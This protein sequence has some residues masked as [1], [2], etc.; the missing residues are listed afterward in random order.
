MT[1]SEHRR[2][3]PF[4]P[5]A[6][7][8]A[9]GSVQNETDHRL[10]TRAVC[11]LV[12]VK[13]EIFAERCTGVGSTGAPAAAVAERA[14]KW[15]INFY[16]PFLGPSHTTKLHRLAVHLL[17]EFRLRGN[18]F[19]G[20][21]GYNATLHKAVKAAYKAPNK[22]RD[23]FVEQLLVN[24]Q[25]AAL[26]LEE[27]ERPIAA[28]SDATSVHAERRSRPLRFSHRCTAAQLARKRKLPGLCT[29][30]EVEDSAS[31]FYCDSIYYG[32]PSAPR[33]G[34]V[35]NTIR[36]AAS[37]HGAPWYDWLQ[38]RGPGGTKCYGQAAL[39]VQSRSGRRK[40]L[41][42]RRA[43]EA[44]PREGCVL[45]DYGCQRLRWAVPSSGNA[46]RLDVVEVNDIV[47]WVAV[48]HDW[49]D[50][51]ERH[52]LLVMPNAVPST[53]AELRAARFFVNAFAVSDAGEETD[54]E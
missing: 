22:R 17:E 6:V 31:L 41:V 38:Y 28:G 36:A 33:R 19:D 32:N 35:A 24:Q 13:N 50:L 8:A 45:S 5:F 51:C 18:L 14:Q 29:V 27:V 23:Q 21:T 43:E 40:R 48:E 52:G 7:V 46:V 4:M 30:L 54:D 39:V 49:E 53:A 1:G 25:V 15:V 9:I 47:G 16:Q 34:R 37:F 2:A 3:L 44:A 42:V 12:A 20:N 10:L 26:L 11:E